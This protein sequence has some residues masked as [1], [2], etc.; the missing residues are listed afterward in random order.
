MRADVKIMH[1]YV[2]PYSQHCKSATYCM[3]GRSYCTIH[4]TVY[5]LFIS[6][7]ESKSGTFRWLMDL[8]I[9]RQETMQ[10]LQGLNEQCKL[11]HH[12]VSVY[13]SMQA[14]PSLHY[15]AMQVL[16]ALCMFTKQ[17]K[18]IIFLSTNPLA[19]NKMKHLGCLLWTLKQEQNLL[20]LYWECSN[21]YKFVV[22]IFHPQGC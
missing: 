9:P 17:I 13:L 3:Q 19:G 21:P 14:F 10:N 18:Q 15:T 12:T 7:K 6:Q 4:H 11:G 22:E 16:S 20:L 8:G 5:C 2:I 1:F